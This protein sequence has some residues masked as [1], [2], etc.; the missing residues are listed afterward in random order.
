MAF[1]IPRD[2]DFQAYIVGL[3]LGQ[4]ATFKKSRCPLPSDAPLSN[5]LRGN[6][7]SFAHTSEILLAACRTVFTGALMGSLAV[8]VRQEADMARLGGIDPKRVG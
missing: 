7:L 2:V 3:L 6:L 5:A 1:L 8:P 4:G